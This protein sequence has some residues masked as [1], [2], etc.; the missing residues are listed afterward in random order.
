MHAGALLH[1]FFKKS[2]QEIHKKRLEA[3]FVT[4]ESLLRGRLLTLSG[5][6][7]SMLGPVAVKH[8]IKRV[9]RL[10]GNTHLHTDRLILYRDLAE[11]AIGRIKQPIILIDWSQLD[12]HDKYYVIRA[13]VPFFGR[14]L[15]IY[16]ETHPKKVYDTHLVNK[17]F[18]L[19]L[20]TLVPS[21]CQPIIVT[22]AGTGFRTPWLKEIT[23]IGWDFVSRIRGRMTMFLHCNAEWA[24]C[25]DLYL[26]AKRQA[27]CLGHG[28]L[29]KENRFA[30]EFFLAKRTIK[31]RSARS[32]KIETHYESNERGF[33][34]RAMEPWLLA[35]SL[36]PDAV[37]PNTIISIYKQRMQIEESFRD[38]K[39]QRLG[40]SL[41][42]T[43][44]QCIHRLNILLLIG[45]I[46]TYIA[47]SIGKVA[48]TLALQYQFQ[49]T[50]VKTK[51]VLSLFN[52]GCQIWLFEKVKIS[53]THIRQALNSLSSC[54]I[55]LECL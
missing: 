7:Q 22:D 52:L 6:G 4:V 16:E 42:K 17:E 21:H 53:I 55:H 36:D 34:R 35:T 32:N 19:A 18:L 27:K 12:E 24:S 38:S 2:A 47:I 10:L 14:G 49:A 11:R 54:V 33:S 44:S 28:L 48:S 40:F 25:H 8:C 31:K 41:K 46:A 1:K 3:L 23:R 45:T 29:T 15:T 26:K 5:L 51:R 43:L 20:K 37:S 30:C 39:N 13:T 9:N 50:S